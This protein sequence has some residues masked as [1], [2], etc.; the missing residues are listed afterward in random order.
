MHAVD[1]KVQTLSDEVKAFKIPVKMPKHIQP[2]DKL[3]GMCDESSDRKMD[4]IKKDII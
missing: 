1:A 4:S 2:L 3:G